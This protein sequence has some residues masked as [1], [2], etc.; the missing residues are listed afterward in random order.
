MASMID[1][2]GRFLTRQSRDFMY[3]ALDETNYKP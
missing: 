2:P 1:N 3:V